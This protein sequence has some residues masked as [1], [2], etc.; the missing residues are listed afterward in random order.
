MSSPQSVLAASGVATWLD[1]ILDLAL[2]VAYIDGLFH[3]R[4]QDFVLAHV[5]AVLQ[6][7]EEAATR[8]EE[9]AWLRSAWKTH[10]DGVLARLHAEI[11]AQVDVPAGGAGTY[12][13]T[14]LK[15]RA[16]TVF[17]GL[18]P[19]AQV[20]AL[21]VL[22]ALIHADGVVT[23][24]ERLLYQELST[25]CGSTAPAAAPAAPAAAAPAIIVR[26]PDDLP[27]LDVSHP[28]LD[29]LEQA[30]S[31]HPVERQAQLA[32]DVA[33]IERTLQTWQRLRERGAGRLA[34][35]T[36]VGQ[37]AR[38][39]RFLDGHV[40]VA[41]PDTPL[42][43]IVLGDLHG[44]YS[45]L[46]AALL[47]SR[48]VERAWAH[49]WDPSRFPDVR[50]VMLG[51]YI[52]RGRFNFDGVLRAALQLQIAFPDQVYV[53]RG[54]HEY[55]VWHDGEV[56]AGV[57]PAEA[58]ASI[59][60]HAPP[61]VLLAYLTLFEHMP[62]SLLVERTLLVHAGIPRDDTF[63]E[64]WRDLS[65]LGDP[66]LRFQMMWSDPAATDH[67][68][69]ELQ[70]AT[71]RFQ[72]GRKQFRAFLDRLGCDVMIRGHEQMDRGFESIYRYE[73]RVLLSVFSAG[74]WDNDDLPE[75][76]GYRSVTPMA[77]TITYGGGGPPVATP[78]RIHYKPFC[79]EPHNGFY[80]PQPL[81]D[82]RYL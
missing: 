27:L 65:S 58:L 8:P 56:R 79:Y 4:E 32:W 60:P 9:R 12:L 11:V 78:W 24:A 69:V 46:K 62:T 48:F 68:P 7:I 6:Q 14:R 54:N 21:E 63:A 43:L 64:R 57:S 36:Q 45:C 70:R 77:L 23:D 52:D 37:L 31:P 59:K 49:Q 40:H 33:Q 47:Q 20:R 16:V 3:P 13:S 26:P 42:E 15:V 44:C 76:A 34:G 74:G 67:V 75:G 66:T 80:R 18:D 2:T 55:L 81:L 73:D 17:R 39:A 61:E 71:P 10:A 29:A 82:Y 5:E 30:Y 72:F 22:Q 19:A 1:A 25:Y 35:L 51:D 53:L 38:G 41:M 28:L 50:L